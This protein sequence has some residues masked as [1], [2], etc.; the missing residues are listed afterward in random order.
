MSDHKV[1]PL[2]AFALL[3]AMFGSIPVAAGADERPS[4]TVQSGDLNLA[5]DAGRAVLQ[6]RI[7][8]AVD[9]VCGPAHPRSTADAQAY[10]TCS[11]TARASAAAQYDA[12]VANVQTGKRIAAGRNTA[13][14]AE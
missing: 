10:A 12:L 8:H 14:P 2:I 1:R 4:V 7:A 5:K 6:Q 13:T 3:S 9:A 11:K